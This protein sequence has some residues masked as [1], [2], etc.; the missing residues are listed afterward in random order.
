MNKLNKAM[1]I[2]TGVLSLSIISVFGL[3]S[4]FGEK[5]LCSLDENR[6]LAPFPEPSFKAIYNGS[7]SEQL[8]SYVTDHFIGRSKWI[9][10][11]DRMQEELSENIVNGVYV[12]SERLLDTTV[13]EQDK[14]TFSDNISV[15]NSF[16]K[17]YDGTA[18]IVAVPSSAGVYG[19]SLP[20]HVISRSDS[21]KI[22]E[23]YDQLSSNVR[24]I[25]AY[26][27]LKM[28]KDNYIFYRND[29]KWTSYGAY[30]VYKTVIQ[31]LGFLPTPYDKYIIS[32]VTDNFRGDLYN[33]TLSDTPKADIIDIYSYPDGAEVISCEMFFNDGSVSKGDIYDMS[34][35]SS[36]DMYSMYLGEDVPVLKIKTSNQNDKKL[37]VIKDSYGDCFVP[38]LIQHY[39]EIIAVSPDQLDIPLADIIDI[40][41]YSQTLFLF[42]I[43]NMDEKMSLEKI[44]E[45]N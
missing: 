2:V 35:L 7:F 24:R 30:C 31:K 26:N 22:N 13:S 16:A 41:D 29:T 38:F 44:T 8:D 21:Q 36:S 9:Y 17:T 14:K 43:N 37:L 20:S 19:D 34:R 4:L 12:S 10:V 11:S 45:R 5:K 3:M 15:I 40:N 32:H 42:G 1:S 33:R 27:I 6:Q 39:S 18:Y 28:M 23:L 25:D